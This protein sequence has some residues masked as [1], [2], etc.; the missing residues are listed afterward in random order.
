MKSENGE[1]LNEII[2]PAAWLRTRV[3]GLIEA[4]RFDQAIDYLRLLIDKSVDEEERCQCATCLGYL[5]LIVDDLES[6]QYWLAQAKGLAPWDPHLNYALGHVALKNRNYGRG[7]LHFLEAFATARSAYDEAEFL[8][9]AALALMKQDG[10]TANVAGMLLGALDRD[11]GNPWILDDL[12]RMYEADQRW[13]ESLEVLSQLE[14]VVRHAAESLVLY[15]APAPRQLLRNRLLGQPARPEELEQRARK[16][17]EAVRQ[18]FEVVLDEHARRGPTDMAALRHP[19]ALSRLIRILEWHDRGLELVVAAQSLWAR[20]CAEGLGRDLGPTRLAAAIQVLVERQHWRIPTPLNDVARFHGASQ[21]A[22]TAAA[23]LVAGKLGVRLFAHT[24]LPQVLNLREQKS[25]E[26][27]SRALL[28]GEHLEAVRAGEI[29]L[30][31]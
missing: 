6:A 30:G 28:F 8:R 9:S 16:I 19:T 10:P 20:A 25:L 7:T 13:M 3:A 14:K 12:A 23:R 21:G 24:E 18:Q 5:Y 4:Q 17:N 22:L 29:R 27:L 26:E 2:D 15:R 11:L 1:N 31:G